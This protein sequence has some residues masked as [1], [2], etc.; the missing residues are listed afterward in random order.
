M[1]EMRPITFTVAT[2]LLFTAI[3][4]LPKEALAGEKVPL[5]VNPPWWSARNS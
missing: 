4:T 5:V 2:D 1:A 3:S